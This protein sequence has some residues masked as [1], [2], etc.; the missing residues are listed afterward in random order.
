[1]YFHCSYSLVC[2]A[3]PRLKRRQLRYTQWSAALIIGAQQRRS[4]AVSQFKAK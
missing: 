1:M 2:A 4:G 3:L